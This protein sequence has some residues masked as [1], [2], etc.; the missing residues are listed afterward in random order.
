MIIP[1]SN[2]MSDE[3]YFRA[4][5]SNDVVSAL[6]DAVD[7]QRN[8]TPNYWAVVPAFVRYNK[9]LTYLEKILYAEIS[10]LSNKMGYC[11][12]TNQYFSDNFGNSD[13]T[14]QR[15]LKNLEELGFISTVKEYV[16]AI[17]V[18]R[19]IFVNAIAPKVS[20]AND[21][22][23][24]RENGNEGVDISQKGQKRGRNSIISNSTSISISK[25]IDKPAQD[26]A[27]KI[28]PELVAIPNWMGK[29]SYARLVKLYEMMWEYKMGTKPNQIKPSSAGS[30]I[31]KTLLKKYTEELSA[32]IIIVHFDWRG[33]NGSDNSIN[34]RMKNA[35]YPITWI[36]NSAPMYE[37]FIKNYLKISTEKEA[38]DRIHKVLTEVSNAP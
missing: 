29:S 36:L 37:S 33:A 11:Y 38:I 17:G 25:D 28:T 32:L 26:N 27:T 12:A 20:L 18:N 21:K 3:E 2:I 9:S 14:I 34:E 24:A 10:A 1:P 6:T 22:N 15:S 4:E 19:K 8:S 23:V 30:G 5:K 16:G 13:M 7:A 31:I 35:G